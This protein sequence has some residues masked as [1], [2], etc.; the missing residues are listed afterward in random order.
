MFEDRVSPSAP[1]T[2]VVFLSILATLKVRHG[3][4]QECGS[5]AVLDKALE[6]PS[7]LLSWWRSSL[8]E[9][10]EF[11]ALR[12]RDAAKEPLHLLLVGLS[13]WSVKALKMNGRK[14]EHVRDK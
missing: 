5:R 14:H 10:K 3:V 13:V 12:W 9:S 4:V 6:G 2:C 7:S 1:S 11:E 8:H